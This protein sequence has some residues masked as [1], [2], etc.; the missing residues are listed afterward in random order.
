MTSM[1]PKAQLTAWIEDI[2]GR[3]ERGELDGHPP[4]QVLPW[5]HIDD[6]DAYTR[7]LLRDVDYWREQPLDSRLGSASIG[8]QQR[9]ATELSALHERLVEGKPCPVAPWPPMGPPR[10]W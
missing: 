7:R 3:L 1:L 10:A 9:I 8:I 5:L 6:V 2:R 4:L